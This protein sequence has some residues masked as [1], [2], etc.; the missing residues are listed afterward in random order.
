MANITAIARIE[1]EARAAAAAGESP[2]TA[3]R[4]PFASPQGVH[5]LATY[6]LHP[7]AL[8]S[9]TQHP[10]PTNHKGT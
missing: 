1:Q 2:D 10:H 3:C 9:A 8:E 5:W 4:W 7:N 6:L